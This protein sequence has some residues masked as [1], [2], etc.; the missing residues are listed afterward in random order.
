[1]ARIA[2]AAKCSPKDLIL[3]ARQPRQ[4]LGLRGGGGRRGNAGCHLPFLQPREDPVGPERCVLD[5]CRKLPAAAMHISSVIVLAR[6][7]SVPRKMPGKPTE[8]LTWLGKS[9][10]PVADDGA[11]ASLASHGQISGIGLAQTKTI[12]SCAIPLSTPA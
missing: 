4:S 3:T 9:L 6:T 5:A 10:R 8:L 11:P 1:M 12:A 7:S 2:N